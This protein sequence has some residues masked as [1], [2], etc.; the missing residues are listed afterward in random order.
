MR[1]RLILLLR[2][3]NVFCVEA[4]LG[5]LGPLGD[6]FG[7]FFRDSAF[8]ETGVRETAVKV[9]FGAQ[10]C[11]EKA[12]CIQKHCLK[13][14]IS[15]FVVPSGALGRRSSPFGRVDWEC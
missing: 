6:I 3:Y 11:G 2:F 9:H 7:V 12:I 5:S 8:I 15:A 10:D 4:V 14:M 13:T 1:L